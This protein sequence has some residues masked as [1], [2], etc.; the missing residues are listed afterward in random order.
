MYLFNQ[1]FPFI[2]QYSKAYNRRNKLDK[3]QDVP[4]HISGLGFRMDELRTMQALAQKMLSL[5]RILKTVM[6]LNIIRTVQRNLFSR[7]SLSW[8]AV[9]VFKMSL[10]SKPALLATSTPKRTIS[11]LPGL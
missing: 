7:H 2:F 1:F 8:E 11:I 4:K 5:F 3:F 10:D 6:C 9:M